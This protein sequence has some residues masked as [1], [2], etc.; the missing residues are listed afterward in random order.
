MLTNVINTPKILSRKICWDL[1]DL[2]S[3]NVKKKIIF[4]TTTSYLQTK[5]KKEFGNDI[6]I[7]NDRERGI[8]ELFDNIDI[9]IVNAYRT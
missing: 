1:L 8:I 3:E 4:S 5:S 2:T 6:D 9:E 7:P